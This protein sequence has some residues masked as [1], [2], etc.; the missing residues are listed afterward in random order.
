MHHIQNK[1]GRVINKIVDDL[2]V[3]IP[4]IIYNPTSGK[5][6]LTTSGQYIY[7]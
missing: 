7:E 3:L 4:S 2:P 5:E 6:I 1:Q